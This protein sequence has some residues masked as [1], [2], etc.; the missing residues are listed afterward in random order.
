MGLAYI[1]HELLVKIR[2][3]TTLEELVELEEILASVIEVVVERKQNIGET[4]DNG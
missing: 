2:G 4:D 1:E 3:L